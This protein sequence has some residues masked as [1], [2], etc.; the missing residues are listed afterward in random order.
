MADEAAVGYSVKELFEKIDKKLDVMSAII[1]SKADHV[2]LEN[3]RK[4]ISAFEKRINQLEAGVA[5]KE[6][7]D[8]NERR[9]QDNEKKTGTNR[10][11]NI[12]AISGLLLHALGTLAMFLQ[13]IR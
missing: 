10:T 5:S 12:I 11:L 13:H 9:L 7:V 1:S 3:A 8:E 4:E 2:D 6:A